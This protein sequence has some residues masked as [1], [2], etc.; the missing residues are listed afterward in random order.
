MLRYWTILIGT[1]ATAFRARKAEDLVPTLRQLQH[2]Q[3]AAILKW[4]ESGR[5]WD[6]PDAVQAERRARA[7]QRERRDVKWRPGGAHRDPRE[8]FKVPREVKKRR[9]LEKLRAEGRLRGPKPRP[10][11]SASSSPRPRKPRR[12]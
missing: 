1:E 9:I 6:S 2:T 5:L 4:Y 12:P 11:T 10:A 7:A 3:P 8:R